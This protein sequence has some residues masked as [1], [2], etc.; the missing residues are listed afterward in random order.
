MSE[1]KM[2]RFRWVMCTLL[3]VATTVNYL[4]RQVLSLTF[5]DF[6]KPEFHWTDADYGVGLLR[7]EAELLQLAD[8]LHHARH[9]DVER[10]RHVPHA[11]GALGVDEDVDLLQV[12]F[13]RFRHVVTGTSR[14]GL[15]FANSF[16]K[17]R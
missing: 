11:R 6:I 14:V 5:P 17:A 13:K 8:R 7:R 16:A 9:L 15:R 3:F 4:D 10:E 1:T 12:V 2:T